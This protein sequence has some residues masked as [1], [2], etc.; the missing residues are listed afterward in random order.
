MSIGQRRARSESRVPVLVAQLAAVA[1]FALL[2]GVILPLAVRATVATLLLIALVPLLI[3]N[4]SRLR[5]TARWSRRLAVG[6]AVFLSVVA[7]VTVADAVV[8]LASIDYTVSPRTLLAALQA[9][10][11]QVIAASV[12]C[13]QLDRGGPVARRTVGAAPHPFPDFRFPEEKA[14]SR[15]SPSYLDYLTLGMTNA[16]AVVP[17]RVVPLRPRAKLLTV[18]WSFASFVLVGVALARIV[19]FLV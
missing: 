18:V 6:Q 4:P 19:L 9:W 13:W 2:P 7:L 17:T 5:Y 3:I 15:F 11:F 8:Q 10:L 16:T 14:E 12:L 1:L